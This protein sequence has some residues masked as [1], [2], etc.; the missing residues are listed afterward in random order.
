M[1]HRGK[2]QKNTEAHQSRIRAETREDR[3]H[4]SFRCGSR[5]GCAAAPRAPNGR[6]WADAQ[7]GSGVY[8]STALALADSCVQRGG[9]VGAPGEGKNVML[10]RCPRLFRPKFLK[11]QRAPPRSPRSSKRRG[12]AGISWGWGQAILPIRNPQDP[13]RGS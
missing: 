5:Q 8:G 4:A 2:Q 12:R 9:G 6:F 7:N 1:S 13:R 3:P 10:Q 11:P